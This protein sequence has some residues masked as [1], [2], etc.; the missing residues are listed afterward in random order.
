M[1][2]LQ[3]ATESAAGNCG[4]F[5]RGFALSRVTLAALARKKLDERSSAAYR[6]IV[7]FAIRYAVRRW[8]KFAGKQAGKR[9]NRRVGSGR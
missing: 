1:P 4:P 6:L 9:R 2:I 3:R 5:A 8:M 7:A